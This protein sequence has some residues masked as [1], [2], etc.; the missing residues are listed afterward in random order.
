MLV[1]HRAG[2][3]PREARLFKEGCSAVQ[4]ALRRLVGE[5]EP[6]S[7][8][9]VAYGLARLELPDRELLAGLLEAS[10]Q[11][12]SKMKPQGLASL[13][14]SF[15]RLN[16]QPPAKWMD[17]FLSACASELDGFGPRDLSTLFLCFARLRYKVAPPRLR[18][19]LDRSKSQLG[20]FCGRSLSSAVNSL[21]HCHEDPGHEWLDAVQARA[22]QLGPD[23]FTPQMKLPELE[24]NQLCNCLWACARLRLF[25]T[26]SWL[27]VFFHASFRS[28][29]LFKPGDLA[30][31]LWALGRLQSHPP[32]EWLAAVLTRL[33]LTASM[34]SPVEVATTM[35][36]LAALG[37]RGQ[38]LPGEVLALWFIATDRRLSSF[39]PAEL[40]S[41]VWALARMGRRP[42]KEWSAELLKVTY[43]K[44]GAMNGWCLGVLAWSLAELGLAPPPAWV[45]SFVNAARALLE[46]TPLPAAQAAAEGQPQELP[47]EQPAEAEP[48]NRR[49]RRRLRQQAVAAAT[50]RRLEHEK[51]ELAG[52]AYDLLSL[53]PLSPS[54]QPVV[55]A[56]GVSQGSQP[57]AGL[58]AAASATDSFTFAVGG[59][60][61]AGGGLTALDLGQIIL[62]LRRLNSRS[63]AGLAKVDAFLEEA[64]A[65][66]REMEAG[67][68]LYAA[69]QLRAF[70]RMNC[71]QAGL[72]GAPA[73]VAAEVEEA[74]SAEGV[75][76]PLAA[77]RSHRGGAERL[78]AQ[79]PVAAGAP[80]ARINGGGAGGARVTLSAATEVQLELGELSV[81]FTSGGTAAEALSPSSW[82][83]QAPS[84]GTAPATNGAE[85]GGVG[86]HNGAAGG[87][88][89][90]G[91]LA[92]EIKRKLMAVP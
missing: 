16:V 50:A 59:L 17:A 42:D 61:Q 74:H 1:L 85:A 25:P 75:M 28:L 63:G 35:W 49:E 77:E 69:G 55:A 82:V 54:P 2:F 7:V 51:L 62:G 43:H 65:R 31:C 87:G 81:G 60:P 78:G 58:A 84:A 30:Q 33:Q 44:L 66:L 47:Q 12:L 29:R 91:Q 26:R 34:F 14:W 13:L 39:R 15:S 48:K 21:A 37:V 22:V 52:A 41:M 38:Q 53:P 46:A 57:A 3:T 89:E 80:A 23:A 36:A 5:L 83:A 86:A 8:V 88:E 11:Q 79:Q 27:V 70:L 76:P 56:A 73:S 32:A 19:L 20:F 64:E 71:K 40:V 45:Y 18:L 92:A 6:R 10:Q 90:T 72:P 67:G 9:A 24:P 4:S 68:G